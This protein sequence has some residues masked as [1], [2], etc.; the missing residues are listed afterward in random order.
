[1]DD[2][3]VLMGASKALRTDVL[4][5]FIMQL[6][7]LEITV[8]SSRE[9]STVLHERGINIRYLGAIAA[10]ATHN[11]IR[12]VAI[13]EVLARSIKVLIRDGLDFLKR[14]T[15]KDYDADAKK[16][17]VYYLNEVFTRTERESS[18]NIWQLL[19]ELV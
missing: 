4:R 14:Q 8:R 17:V 10:E 2:Q 13:R 3:K 5:R 12:E 19:T 11:F 16:F 1:M 7:N 18:L 9:F 6:N 15:N